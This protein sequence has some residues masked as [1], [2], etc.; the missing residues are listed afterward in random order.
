MDFVA[1][2]L[3]WSDR[4]DIIE[5]KPLVNVEKYKSSIRRWSL[6]KSTL[7]DVP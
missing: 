7:Q 3:A 4:K 2:H 1:V 5:F 6:K